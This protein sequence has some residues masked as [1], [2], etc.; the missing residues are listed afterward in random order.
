MNSRPLPEPEVTALLIAPGRPLAEAFRSGVSSARIFQVL[1]DLKAYPAPQALEIRVRQLKPDVI[2]LDLATDLDIALSLIQAVTTMDPPVKVVGIHTNQ[3]SQAVLRSLRAGAVEFLHAPFD[4]ATHN[5]AY[6]RLRRLV[7]PAPLPKSKVLGRTVA[8]AS[9]K[10][11][12]GASTLATQTAF[13]LH[14]LTGKRVLL[15]ECDLAGGTIAFYLKLTHT[16]SMVDALQH[17]DRMDATMWKS[18]AIH[19]QGVDVL[20]APA[21]PYAE[22]VDPARLRALMDQARAYY[23][24]VVLD[25][26]SVFNPTSLMTVTDCDLAFLVSTPELASLHL[27]RKVIQLVQQLGFPKDR[28]QILVNRTSRQQDISTADMEK[29]FDCGVHAR[30]PGDYFALHRVVTLGQPLG[31]DGELGRSIENL[32]RGLAGT[33][34]AEAVRELKPALSGA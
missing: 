30:I 24:W 27:T 34:T 7:A 20:P 28:F 22:P 6:S 2:L 3:D 16:H 26:P 18:L 9:S 10:P 23:D 5:E 4:P 13:S 17:V 11:G 14:R 29:L 21:A 12:S 15:V 8:F 1:A 33:N 25:L 31:G 32:A 19:H